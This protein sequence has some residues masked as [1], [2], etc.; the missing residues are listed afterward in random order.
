MAQEAAGDTEMEILF[1][2][3][4]QLREAGIEHKPLETTHQ[5]MLLPLMTAINFFQ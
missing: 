2:F 4:N 3:N 5:M 1:V